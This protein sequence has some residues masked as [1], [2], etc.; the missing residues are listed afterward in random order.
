MRTWREK[1]LPKSAA[2]KPDT[3]LLIHTD[4]WLRY[5]TA[6]LMLGNRAGLA[7]GEP[8]I[9]L[10]LKI[11]G[12]GYNPR[13]NDRPQEAIMNS[14]GFRSNGFTLIELLVVIAIIAILAAIL[15]PVFARARENA[16]RASCQSNLKQ[17]ALGIK[18]YVQDYDERFPPYNFTLPAPNQFHHDGWAKIIQPYLKSTQI[19]QCPS[20]P[21]KTN[22]DL[23]GAS[24]PGYGG[25]IQGSDGVSGYCDYFYN[26]DLGPYNTVG[27]NESEIRNSSVVI[28]IGDGANAR[29]DQYANCPVGVTCGNGNYTPGSGSS[30]PDATANIRHLEGANYGFVD[31]HVK[32][33]KPDATTYDDPATGSKATYRIN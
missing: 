8:S 9:F 22:T 12:T 14:K 27:K 10:C 33:L 29:D 31:G 16:R 7:A 19:L 21:R 18:Q 13:C 25:G 23:F 5:E 30:T 4:I 28:M 2:G 24:T 11:T 26:L 1:H 3:S 15:F 6:F 17:I 20:E 32:W